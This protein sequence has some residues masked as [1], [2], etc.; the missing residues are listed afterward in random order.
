MRVFRINAHM[1]CVHTHH[2]CACASELE[3]GGETV[4]GVNGWAVRFSKSGG[5]LVETLSESKSF[6]ER[7]TLLIFLLFS[8]FFTFY[9]KS[10]A[11]EKWIIKKLEDLHLPKKEI[12]KTTKKIKQMGLVIE[13]NIFVNVYE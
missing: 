1:V 11:I 7:Q 4:G 13:V 9:I 3:G 5:P 8:I 10:K 2:L 6:L 12:T